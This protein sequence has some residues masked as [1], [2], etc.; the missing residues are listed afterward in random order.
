[1]ESVFD[2][3]AQAIDSEADSLTVRYDSR[4]GYPVTVV[5][6][7]IERAADD[8]LTVKVTEYRTLSE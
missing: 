7:Y 5:I 2:V 1:M 6:D 3:V 4:R 8:E